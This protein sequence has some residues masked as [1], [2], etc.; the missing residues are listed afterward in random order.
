VPTRGK[1]KLVEQAQKALYAVYKQSILHLM[2]MSRGYLPNSPYTKQ[3]GVGSE[4]GVQ[5]L[6]IP[7]V[8]ICILSS[9]KSFI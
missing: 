2:L 4:I 3:F 6:V 8:V 5:R 1:K 9:S 7:L